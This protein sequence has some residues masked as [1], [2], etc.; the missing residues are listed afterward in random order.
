M[1]PLDVVLVVDVVAVPA[2]AVGTAGLAAEGQVL[3]ARYLKLK[4]RYQDLPP[5]S[6]R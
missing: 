4:S 6:G 2:D 5:A 3:V 1:P